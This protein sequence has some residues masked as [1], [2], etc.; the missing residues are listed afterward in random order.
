MEQMSLLA[1]DDGP[2]EVL[3]SLAEE[4]WQLICDGVKPYEYRRMYR[5]DRTRA[6]IV[7]TGPT[8]GVVGYLELARPMIKTP[9]EIAALA[10]STRPG[11]GAAVLAY[12]SD[13]ASGFAIPIE[14]VFVGPRVPMRELRHGVGPLPVPQSYLLVQRN[15]ALAEF[16][17]SWMT[18]CQRLEH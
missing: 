11:N 6:F 16:L 15:P 17:H 1:E 7:T 14:Q 3:L 4:Y 18:G 9:R 12:L 10:E 5:R 8:S 13:S 2:T